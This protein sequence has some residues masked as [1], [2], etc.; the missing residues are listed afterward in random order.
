M[1]EQ[2]HHARRHLLRGQA[3]AADGGQRGVAEGRVHHQVAW[4]VG[5][6]LHGFDDLLQ[7]HGRALQPGVGAGAGHLQTAGQHHVFPAHLGPQA[8]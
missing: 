1:R 7:R 6:A 3:L 4:A 2:G 5:R 8:G